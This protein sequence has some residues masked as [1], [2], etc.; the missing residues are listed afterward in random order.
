VVTCLRI[1]DLENQQVLAGMHASFTL[2]QPGRPAS[3]IGSET[4]SAATRSN[5]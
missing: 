4:A 2:E 3:N 5:S 1:D